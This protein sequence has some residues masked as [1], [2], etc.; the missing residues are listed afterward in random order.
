M[1]GRK[2]KRER[3]TGKKFKI[4]EEEEIEDIWLKKKI[5]GIPLFGS[6]IQSS[7]VEVLNTE[8]FR[9]FLCFL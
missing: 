7:K 5:Y 6:G 3:E 2:Y 9:I 1:W 8:F 4:N